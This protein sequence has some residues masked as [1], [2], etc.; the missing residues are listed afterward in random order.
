[1]NGWQFFGIAWLILAVAGTMVFFCGILVG[2][3]ADRQI[4]RMRNE[5]KQRE[6]QS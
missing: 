1:M 2:Q 3:R 4:E 6:Q 5:R